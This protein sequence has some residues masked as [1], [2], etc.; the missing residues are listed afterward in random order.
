MRHSIDRL[1]VSGRRL[2][3][4]GWA[5]HGEREIAAVHLRLEGDGWERRLEAGIGLARQDVRDAYP[6]LVNAEASG[7]VVT[8]YIPAR[9]PRR[10]WLEVELEDG[11]AERVDVTHIVETRYA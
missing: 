6:D 9:A 5:A 8:G 10:A 3:G 7:F 4:W 1:V 11:R 2:F